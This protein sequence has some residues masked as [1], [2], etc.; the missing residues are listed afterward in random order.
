[1]GKITFLGA[2]WLFALCGMTQAASSFSSVA[3]GGQHNLALASDGTV[4]AWGLYDSAQLDVRTTNGVP[5]SRCP[6][7]A[8]SWRSLPVMTTAWR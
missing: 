8:G 5:P 7:L 2:A 3:A 6:G 4:W 1:M